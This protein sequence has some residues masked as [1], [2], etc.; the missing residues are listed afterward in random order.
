M[1]LK[2]ETGTLDVYMILPT[3]AIVYYPDEKKL[4]IGF[5]FLNYFLTI[6]LKIK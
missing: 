3:P 4:E 6:N 2:F 1:K 5:Y